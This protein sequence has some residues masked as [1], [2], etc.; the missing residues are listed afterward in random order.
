[1]LA[2]NAWTVIVATALAAA[3]AGAQQPAKP[4][5]TP[6]RSTTSKTQTP[7][8][9]KSNA[10]TSTAAALPVNT[11]SAK[12][13]VMANVPGASITSTHLRRSSS[14]SYYSVNYKE[15]GGRKTMHATVDANTGVFT[16]TPVTTS[17]ARPAAKK[18][19]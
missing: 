15:K 4:T 18:P 19:S 6:A 10:K 8:A 3:A 5:S 11:D 2:R 13:I 17:T 12:K 16:A 9:A 1:M 14:K 7:A